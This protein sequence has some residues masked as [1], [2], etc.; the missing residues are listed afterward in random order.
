M[1]QS[2]EESLLKAVKKDDKKAFD[3]LMEKAQCGAYRLGRFPVL[4]LMYLYKSHK[5]LAAYEAKFLKITGFKPLQEPA[6]VSKKFSAKAGK[7]LRLYFDEV[8]SPLEM[9]LI[10]D[11]L[12]R[13]KRIYPQTNPSEA[14]KDR[15]KSIYFI[16]YSLNIRFEGNEILIDRRPLSY[17]EKR[18][19]AAVCLCSVLV[20]SVA[21]TV[22][23]TVN[24]F[25]ID[26]SSKNEY[27]LKR[28]VVFTKPVEE[29][30][31]KIFG[32]GHK[33]IFK[34]GATVNEFNGE[35]SDVTIESFGGAPFTV[36]SKN[37]AIKNVTV[38]VDADITTAE[39]TAFVAM[40]NFGLIDEVTLNVKGKIN[41][42]ASAEVSAEELTFG[43]IVQNNGY[44]VSNQTV[45]MGVISNCT[46]N[47]SGLSLIG[48]ASANAVFGGVAGINGGYVQD[49][50]VTGEIVSDTFDIGGICSVNNWLLSGNVN[51]ANLSQTSADTGWNPITCGIAI[52]NAYAIENC[53]NKGKISAV[54]TAPQY[55]E[56]GENEHTVAAAGITYVCTFPNG[57]IVR[58]I[59]EGSVSATGNGAAYVGG[60]SAI[61]FAK[62]SYCLSSGGITASAN[63]V[64]AGGIFG[65]GQVGNSGPYVYV[66]M[67]DYCISN[68]KIDV[69]AT[70]GEPARVGG[71]V[72]FMLEVK[73]ISN[74]TSVYFG[75]C[76]T[77]SYFT[78]ECVKDVACFG[79]IVGV[80]G[81]H[82]YENNSYTAGT[83]EYHNFED[84]YYIG[85][86][87]AAFGATMDAD[88]NFASVGDKGATSATI[89]EIKNSE[90]YKA[91]LDV[92][93]K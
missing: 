74:E 54:S 52:T 83:S 40:T 66:G 21:V 11:R 75:G 7:C 25:K 57:S 6:E 1:A 77:N 27:T 28:D 43:G 34:N 24:E 4:S 81:A 20:V 58:C 64:C 59:N 42:L 88:G 73:F 3:A 36:V 92:L 80:C 62:I 63:S 45:R 93:G 56:T 33:L 67:A 90:T 15:L 2:V 68:G 39:E 49:C 46:V 55:D 53:E 76:V 70:G 37:A 16:K 69:T 47:Y 17:R 32:N 23:V 48:E 65:L 50:S 82:I 91:I 84:N 60:I 41:A 10:L 72:G 14:V 61:T 79:N 13:L 71:V 22:P 18:N 29:V 51:A 31:C 85:N 5:L 78:G 38:N 87:S 30:N 35:L 8:V 12:R 86:S 44:S 26:F 19:I 89:E 9:L